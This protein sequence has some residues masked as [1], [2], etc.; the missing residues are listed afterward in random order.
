[1]LTYPHFFCL[2]FNKCA[3]R[4]EYSHVVVASENVEVIISDIVSKL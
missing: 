3:M 4:D 1:M 2:N